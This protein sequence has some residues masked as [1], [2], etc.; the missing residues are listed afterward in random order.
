MKVALVE[1]RMVFPAIRWQIHHICGLCCFRHQYVP[2]YLA[3]HHFRHCIAWSHFDPLNHCT[4]PESHE[5]FKTHRIIIIFI[6]FMG[7]CVA[8][9]NYTKIHKFH[10]KPIFINCKNVHHFQNCISTWNES[11]KW[12]LILYYS[13]WGLCWFLLS[14][15]KTL[16]LRV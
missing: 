16:F 9:K 2:C 1:V 14:F 5:I 3:P 10:K 8:F 7:N 11:P 4:P 6:F 13:W 12:S 15:V